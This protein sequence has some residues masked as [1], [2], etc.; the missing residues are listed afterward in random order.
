ML[1]LLPIAQ[2]IFLVAC[3]ALASTPTQVPL[4][5]RVVN[6]EQFMGIR[7]L[8]T[9][10]L[11]TEFAGV[12]VGGLSGLAWDNDESLLY[13]ISDG[14]ELHHFQPVFDD[15]GFLADIR[16]LASFALKDAE[17][18]PLTAPW[19]DSEGLTLIN[20]DNG[21]RGD[22]ELLVSFE[23]RMRIRRYSNTGERLGGIQL[24]APLRDP[25][26]YRNANMSLE[27]IT[28]HPRWDVLVAPENSLRS[29]PRGSVTL[30][31]ST[32]ERWRYPLAGAPRSSLVAME[33]LPDGSVMF[34]ERAFTSLMQPLIISLRRANLQA[35]SDAPLTVED[36]AVLDS[37]KGW[38]L[39]NFEGL[40][41]YRDG[42]FFMVSDD[43]RHFLQNTLLVFFELISPEGIQP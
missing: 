37:S 38:L 12:T 31:S 10:R 28:T 20:G 5:E 9:L 17:S 24:P 33:T 29:D 32:G 8:G 25:Q 43:N 18:R 3:S 40:T 23:I 39:D 41:P 6:G 11:P 15:D 35:A 34:L 36:I 27:A 7:L 42:R 21:I 13:A 22:T 16:H 4:S 26:R 1:R 19:A 30:F 14:G 2:V